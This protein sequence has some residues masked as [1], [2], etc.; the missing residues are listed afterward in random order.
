[1]NF[2]EYIQLSLS[3]DVWDERQEEVAELAHDRIAS[4]VQRNLRSTIDTGIDP[5]AALKAQAV[6]VAARGN[7]LI[8][9]TQDQGILTGKASG[10]EERPGEGVLDLFKEG[11]GV[12]RVSTDALGNTRLVYREVD[13]TRLFEEKPSGY[14]DESV[15]REVVETVR[16]DVGQAYAD[17][18]DEVERKYPVTR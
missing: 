4:A 15:K 16:R 12:P 2:G 7:R 3:G 11:T 8:I 14:V 18:I 13:P 1:M 9:D 5:G 17:A 6:R 10:H